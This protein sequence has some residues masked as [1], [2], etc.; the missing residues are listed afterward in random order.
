[1]DAI[2]EIAGAKGIPVVEDASQAQGR[3]ISTG[4]H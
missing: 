3:S 2:L 1:M 4:G